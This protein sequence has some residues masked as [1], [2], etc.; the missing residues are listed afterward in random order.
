MTLFWIVSSIITLKAVALITL[1]VASPKSL[2]VETINRDLVL[3]LDNKRLI[4]QITP[5]PSESFSSDHD[6]MLP[7]TADE[8]ESIW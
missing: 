4:Q 6:V 1:A 5:A 3:R 2:S 7:I 8:Y